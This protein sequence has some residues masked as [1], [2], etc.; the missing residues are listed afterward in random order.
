MV[1][2]WQRLLIETEPSIFVQVYAT[3]ESAEF[4]L[5]S[6][7]NL[8]GRYWG[9]RRAPIA[10][11]P[12]TAAQVDRDDTEAASAPQRLSLPT[13]ASAKGS[14]VNESDEDEVISLLGLGR[15]ETPGSGVFKYDD[16]AFDEVDD[17]SL[18]LERRAYYYA[19][20]W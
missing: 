18:R 5:A 1:E 4:P 7:V 16:T 15:E 6:R 13:M 9:V 2:E 8:V 12:E 11:G 3:G 17:N 20:V 10:Q 19:S 14:L